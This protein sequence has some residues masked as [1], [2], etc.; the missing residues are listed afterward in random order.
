[1]KKIKAFLI[2]VVF[3][4]LTGCYKQEGII[5]INDDKSVNIEFKTLV[6]DNFDEKNYISNLE[7]Y[8]R[9]G[10]KIQRINEY[11]YKGY[12]ISKK[13]S[14]IDDISSEKETSVEIYKFLDRNFNDKSLFTRNEDFFKDTY[15]ARFIVDNS[16]LKNNN[17]NISTSDYLDEIKE[18]YSKAI[19][20]YGNNNSELNYNNKTNKLD[21]NNSLIYNLD[22]DKSGNVILIEVKNNYYYYKKSADKILINDIKIEDIEI[23]NNDD[24]VITFVVNLPKQSISNNASRVSD[25]GKTLTWIFSKNSS[26]NMIEFTFEIQNKQ[27][28][29]II[30]E[31]FMLLTICF[32][33]V[34]VLSKKIKTNKRE[35]I[36]NNNPIYAGYDE[37]IEDEALK[38]RK[39]METNIVNIKI[40]KDNKE[41]LNE[42]EIIDKQQNCEIIEIKDEN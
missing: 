18:L 15:S 25:D 21:V 11:G 28:F 32:T 19:D 35:K 7:Y 13:Y 31:I 17:K 12:K 34:I 39:N 29:Y 36:E 42:D 2:L 38:E 30:I 27:H 5:T 41:K 40:K 33:I 16:T 6:D 4:L 14:N 3:V 26:N 8:D 24:D 1:M 37:S 10:I 22:F 23:V 20:A 9:N